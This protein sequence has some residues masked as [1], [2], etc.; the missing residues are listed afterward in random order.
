V[1]E[2]APV[3]DAV[4]E[5][6]RVYTAVTEETQEAMAPYQGLGYQLG[7][8]QGAHHRILQPVGGWIGSG[9]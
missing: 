9:P 8:L 1:Y 7:R 5:G 3:Y 4:H 6:G 2:V